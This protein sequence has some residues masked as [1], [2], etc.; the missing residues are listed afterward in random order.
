MNSIYATTDRRVSNSADP[1]DD[2][3]KNFK[4]LM[5]RIALKIIITQIPSRIHAFETLGQTSIH[6][7]GEVFGI[8]LKLLSDGDHF[9]PDLRLASLLSS[10]E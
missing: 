7:L 9:N 3:K 1:F 2:R 5:R 10:T 8:V 6:P 4:H